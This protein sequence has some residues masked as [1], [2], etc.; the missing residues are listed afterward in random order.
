VAERLLIWLQRTQNGPQILLAEPLDDPDAE[1]G[2][3]LQ[4]SDP[5]RQLLE[6]MKTGP[7]QPDVVEQVGAVLCQSLRRQKAIERDFKARL[8]ING[9]GPIYLRLDPPEVEEWPWEA[10]NDPDSGFLAL[11]R[12]WPIARVKRVSTVQVKPEYVFVPP[13]RL[14]A[15]LGASGTDALTRISAVEEWR[16]LFKA[17]RDCGLNVEMRVFVCEDQLRDEIQQLGEP[18]ITVDFLDEDRELF[19][20]IRSFRPQLL[21]FFCHGLAGTPPVLQ[22]A[23]RRD[24]KATLDGSINV[25]ASQLRD[26]ADPDQNVWLITLNCCESAQQG[27]GAGSRS[28]PMASSLVLRGFP[29]VVGMRQRVDSG[30][31][32][33]F[34]GL[35]YEAVLRELRQAFSNAAPNTEPEPFHWAT[36]LFAARQGILG[37]VEKVQ[38]NDSARRNVEWTIPVLYTRQQPFVVRLAPDADGTHPLLRAPTAA[39]PPKPQ[40]SLDDK[41]RLAAKMQELLDARD[42]FATQTN[43]PENV[44]KGVLDAI[45]QELQSIEAALT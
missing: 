29:A 17:V 8:A 26:R 15:V 4:L 21:H 28:L 19:D 5:E 20:E 13:L 14:M 1:E 38:L 41:L 12:R 32:N 42:K 2:V 30:H 36:G 44:R 22:I 6:R 33:R 35:W 16:E 34:C 7:W 37:L 25:E 43:L 31:A 23:A 11:E 40:L 10:L 24:W 27:Q 3:T 45:N 18:W 9:E 39:P